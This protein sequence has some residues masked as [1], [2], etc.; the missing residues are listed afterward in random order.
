MSIAPSHHRLGSILDKAYQ[1]ETMTK[2]EIIFILQLRSKDHMDALFKT[3]R[4]LRSRYFQDRIFLYGFLY[5]STYCRNN[6]NFCFY[7]VSNTKSLRYRKTESQI[8]EAAAALARSGVHLIDLTMGEDPEFFNPKGRGFDPIILLVEAIKTTTGLPVMVSPGVVS[9]QVL[10]NLAA[11]GTTWYACYQETHRRTL[12]EKLRP[13]QNYHARL[14][15]KQLAHKYDLLT[16]EGILV[17][18]GETPEDI[19]HTIDIMHALDAD[20]VRVMNFV[21]RKGTPME[22]HPAPDPLQELLIIALMRLIFP[23]KLIPAT[24]DVEGLAGL[25]QRLEAGANVVTSIV[26]PQQGLAGVAQ[27]SLDIEDARRTTARVLPVLETCGLRAA[28]PEEY[29]DWIDKRKKRIKSEIRSTKFETNS[30]DK[31]AKFKMKTNE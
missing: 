4:E 25:R 18:V 20:Q 12:F 6:C 11:A 15:T 17:G 5:I 29:I 22:S 23:D 30:N 8:L 26:P 24:L 27:S 7:R 2:E 16:E 21:P 28:D 10:Q 31:N 9:E 3:A 1:N 14:N 19:A 13:G